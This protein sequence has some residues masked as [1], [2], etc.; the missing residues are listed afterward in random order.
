[1]AASF[2]S[3]RFICRDSPDV[4][5]K[6]ETRGSRA[7]SPPV[8]DHKLLTVLHSAEKSASELP[9]RPE[10]RPGSLQRAPKNLQRTSREPPESAPPVREIASRVQRERLQRARASREIVPPKREPSR[11]RASRER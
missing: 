2:P 7:A 11:E 9:N 5:C 3:N 10:Q 1:M 6:E 4:V 8:V